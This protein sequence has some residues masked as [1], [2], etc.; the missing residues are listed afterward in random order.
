MRIV[1]CLDSINGVGGIQ[2]VA[3]IK[4]NSLAALPENEVWIIVAD[5]SGKRFLS[6]SLA[7][8]FLDL[9]INYYKDDWKSWFHAL[10]GFFIKRIFVCWLQYGDYQ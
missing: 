10:K 4:A 9:E 3:L 6:L 1:Y 7:I 2:R 8:H 5:N